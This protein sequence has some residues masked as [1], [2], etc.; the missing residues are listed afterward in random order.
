MGVERKIIHARELLVLARKGALEII[1]TNELTPIRRVRICL[2]LLAGEPVEGGLSEFA[3]RLSKLG[4]DQKHYWVGTFY[5]LLLSPAV[6][7]AQAAYFT[8]PNLS[9][10]LIR[11]VREQGFDPL[12]HTAIDPAA[13]G[14]AFLSTLAGEMRELGASPKDIL[15]RLHGIEI[16]RG[17]A[18]LSEALIADRADGVIA[19]GSVVEVRDA[20]KARHTATYNLVIA[21]PPYGRISADAL[22]GDAWRDV[23]HPGHINKY[24]LFAERCFRLAKPGGL[25]ALVL[26]SSF[27]AGPLYGKLRSYMR[28]KGEIL[29]LGSVTTRNDVFVDVT[30][31][32]SI[33]L[34]R[35]G[36]EHRAERAVSFGNVTGFGPFRSTFATTLPA[37]SEDAWMSAGKQP[38]LAIGGATLADYG[39]VLRVGYFVWN[40]ELERMSKRRSAKLDMPLVWARNIRPGAFCFPK[41]KRGNGIDFVRFDE[42]SSGIV[43]TNAIVLQRTTNS[44]QS[45]RLIAARVS[46]SVIKKWGGFVTENHTLVITGPNVA[47]LNALCFL[48]N[49][50][51]VDTRYR[52]LSGTA[53]ISANLLRG[54]DLPTPEALAE[55][56][57]AL[58][59]SEAAVERA[60][61]RGLPAKKKLTA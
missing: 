24:A 18:R 3:S 14:A 5:T 9:K 10:A 7:R 56:V 16:D 13:G 28:E 47:T 1:H 45:R 43:R 36:T 61:A 49:S 31:D 22:R 17:L 12:R 42:E 48:L 21:N 26:P 50:A 23:C 54:L 51:A 41:A 39:A 29:T 52:Q 2:G 4:V 46:P 30:Q 53:S 58:G 20:L 6:R 11:L 25:V 55:A 19:T 27:M 59:L 44:A 38:G 33:V 15:R 57:D 37:N 40:R 35:V 60:Y 32:V 34:A 8:P